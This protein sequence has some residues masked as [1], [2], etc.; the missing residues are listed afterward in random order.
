MSIDLKNLNK[1]DPLKR[2]VERQNK[3]EEFSPMDPPD[4]FQPPALDE[5]KYEDMHPIIQS[6]MDEHKEC[7]KVINTFENTLNLLQT[8]GFSKNTFEEINDFFSFFDDVIIEHNRKEDNTIFADLN[9]ILH[10]KEEFST[11]AKKTVVD[12]MEDDHIKMLQLAAISFNLFGLVTRIPDQNSG[13]VILDLAIEQSKALIEMLKLH[14]FREDNVVFPMA[15]NYL[16][17][18]SLDAM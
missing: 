12:L 9:T 17:I 8:S 14:I 13:M 11:G 16:P 1:Q 15:N 18:K 4:A 3:T 10:E 5:V 2:M 6:L 7:N